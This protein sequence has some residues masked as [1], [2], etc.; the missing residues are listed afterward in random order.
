MKPPHHRATS[1]SGQ[2][3]KG[4]MLVSH[5]SNV[6]SCLLQMNNQMGWAI[7][8]P[9][10]KVTHLQARSLETGAPLCSLPEPS[11]HLSH[12]T[13]MGNINRQSLENGLD[14][15]RHRR[16]KHGQLVASSVCWAVAK[17]IPLCRGASGGALVMVIH[18]SEP[19]RLKW[20]SS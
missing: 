11:N 9:K 19:L 13:C 3:Q 8:R 10:D 2:I 15:Q 20:V 7:H 12:N 5:R 4:L 14:S 6:P 16:P 1:L 18:N 17:C